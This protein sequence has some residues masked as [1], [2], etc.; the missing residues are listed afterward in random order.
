MQTQTGPALLRSILGSR[1]GCSPE[2]K[3][4]GQATG[5]EAG[6][7]GTASEASPRR[8][9][10]EQMSRAAHQVRML[11]PPAPTPLTMRAKP[12]R[13]TFAESSFCLVDRSVLL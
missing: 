7:S 5:K 10:F 4:P 1:P 11:P 6:H 2:G 3:T 12:R 8:G 13:R 9:K